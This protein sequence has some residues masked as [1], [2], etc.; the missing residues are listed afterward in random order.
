MDFKEMAR[1]LGR[2]G[3]LA[4]RGKTSARKKI[5]SRRNGKLGGRPRKQSS[6]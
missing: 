2:R 1:L 3:G 4:S 5:A 6:K